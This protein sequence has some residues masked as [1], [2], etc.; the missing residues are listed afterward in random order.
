MLIESVVIGGTLLGSTAI[1]IDEKNI[2][3]YKHLKTAR[4][5]TKKA[6]DSYVDDVLRECFRNNKY[7][8]GYRKIKNDAL[9]AEEK[10]SK[11]LLVKAFQE[12]IHLA[13]KFMDDTTHINC[14]GCTDVTI[15]SYEPEDLFTIRKILK[16]ICG[17]WN[18]KIDRHYCSNDKL[19]VYYKGSR[20]YQPFN[21]TIDI[22]YDLD[23]LP[24]GILKEGCK[25]I[26]ETTTTET[27]RIECAI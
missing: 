14:Y 9:E 25:V 20:H 23:K 7:V 26:K 19:T 11:E 8:Q 6:I 22:V 3:I 18:D 21:I 13:K 15:Y 2:D 24:D 17:N 12:Q 4:V 1:C 5:A 10:A 16:K 27:C